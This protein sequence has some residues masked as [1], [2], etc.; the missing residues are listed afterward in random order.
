V[1]RHDL[2]VYGNVS[3][4]I[5]VREPHDAARVVHALDLATQRRASMPAGIARSPTEHQSDAARLASGPR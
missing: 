2:R 5:Y 1:I 4:P 3:L